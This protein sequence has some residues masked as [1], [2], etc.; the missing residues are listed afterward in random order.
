MQ[1]PPQRVLRL[2]YAGVAGLL[3]RVCGDR[4]LSGAGIREIVAGKSSEPNRAIRIEVADLL[5]GRN[6]S[7]FPG[8]NAEVAVYERK[9]GETL[10]S[11]DGIQ[12]REQKAVRQKAAD[13]SPDDITEG[14]GRKERVNTNVV[15]PEKTG[16]RFCLYDGSER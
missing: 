3:R 10:I 8:T 2:S 5:S 1:Q 6:P 16:R 15:I 13:R 14:K 9:T 7:V 12:V 4:V 11:D